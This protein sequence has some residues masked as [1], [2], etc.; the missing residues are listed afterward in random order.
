ML[1]ERYHLLQG[2]IFGLAYVAPIG[3]QNLYV[4]NTATQKN[5]LKTYQVALITVIFDIS[6][7]ISCFLGIGLLIDKFSVLKGIILLLGSIIVTYIGIGL[8]R[9][10]SQEYCKK[11]IDNSLIKIIGSCFA[12]TWLNPQA[13][14]DGSLLLGGFRTSLPDEMSKYF[15]LGVCIASFI[16]FNTLATV[17]SKVLNRF[18]NIIK[19]INIICGSILIFYGIK[20]GYSFFQLI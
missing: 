13:I 2:L 12:V 16:W 17:I 8:I 14:I 18:N 4:I 6:L 11:D 10:S 9:S 1:L 7:A 3:T 15:I 20:L 5:T 19:W